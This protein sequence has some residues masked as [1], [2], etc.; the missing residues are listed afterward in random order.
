MR[1]DAEFDPRA[2]DRPEVRVVEITL[3]EMDKIAAG[4]NRVLPKIID[5]E[6]RAVAFAKRL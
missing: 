5:N 1:G 2:A 4:T 3:A 6:L